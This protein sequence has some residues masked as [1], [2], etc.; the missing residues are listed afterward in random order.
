MENTGGFMAEFL[1]K[2]KNI[3]IPSGIGLG[4]IIAVILSM[5]GFANN[6]SKDEKQPPVQPTPGQQ[7]E[8]V[9]VQPSPSPTETPT[10]QEVKKEPVKVKG[11]YLTGWSVGYKT[12][13]DRLL[14]LINTTE[15]NSMIIDVKDDK[16]KISYMTEVP[17]AADTGAAINMVGDINAVMATLK[18]NNIYPIARIVCFK[19]PITSQKHPELAIKNKN[20]ALWRDKKGNTWLDPYNKGSWQFLIDMS[21]EAVQKGF[22]EIQ[23]DYIRFPTDGDVNA[24][25]YGEISQ[26][27]SKSEA[28][29]EFL[30]QAKKELTPL[31][32]DI[33]ADVFGIIPVSDYDAKA[34]GQTIEIISK[35]ID[36]ICP[37]VYPSHYA[38]GQEV[39]NIAYK[40]PDLEP[41]G[42][43]Y[44]S[45]LLAK[46][47]VTAS[48]G[49]AKIRPYLQDFTASWLGAGNYQKYGAQ[50]LKEQI[51]ATYD[52]GLEE[53]IL[54]NADNSYS[55]EGLLKE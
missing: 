49:N 16:G 42:V 25:Q 51:K 22:K 4:V 19:D 52:A 27:Q 40:K 24:I 48:N 2:Y 32:V 54:W 44:N 31:G 9:Q 38:Y 36:Y 50:Q 46:Q 30:A 14:N 18:D 1:K 11:I 43:V 39:N 28:I 6:Q 33:S 20:G 29:A 7:Q 35:D 34:I 13:F 26:T 41:Y 12:R 17:A 53:W 5:G 21:K 37:M 15:L 10:P 3:L 47:R 23:Y 55:E 8:S 45:L